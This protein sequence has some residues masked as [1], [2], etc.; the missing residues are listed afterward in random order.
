MPASV[1][2]YLRQSASKIPRRV[3]SYK[4][5][6]ELLQGIIPVICG[7]RN[8]YMLDIRIGIEH[9]KPF[10]V[11]LST[12]LEVSLCILCLGCDD[13][14]IVNVELVREV[15]NDRVRSSIIYLPT[16]EISLE[17]P[18]WALQVLEGIKDCVLG[19]G[20][21]NIPP[22][23]IHRYPTIAG[24]LL[25]YPFVYVQPPGYKAI[26]D[27]ILQVYN[28]YLSG[29]N[30]DGSKLDIPLMTCSYPGTSFDSR[31]HQVLNDFVNLFNFR[32]N[33]IRRLGGVRAELLFERVG[34]TD[35][36]CVKWNMYRVMHAKLIL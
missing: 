1:L 13:K 25:Q 29:V 10:L 7:L 31:N 2:D 17:I 27:I 26:T 24:I 19:V 15:I 22:V 11:E 16:L 20:I 28:F 6:C 35:D 14:L 12:F 23:D 36:L 18:N 30:N 8:A 4:A 32:L 34:Y 3:L 33:E 21:I 5:Q 9:L